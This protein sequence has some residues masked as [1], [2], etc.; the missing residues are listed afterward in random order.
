MPTYHY[1]PAVGFPMIGGSPALISEDQ[2]TGCCCDPC[3]TLTPCTQ[4]DTHSCTKRDDCCF[5]DESCLTVVVNASSLAHTQPGEDCCTAHGFV[6]GISGC[7]GISNCDGP[8]YSKAN[9]GTTCPASCTTDGDEGFG[10]SARIAISYADNDAT[11]TLA[12]EAWAY[13]EDATEETPMAFGRG[14]SDCCVDE[15]TI[16]L[17]ANQ[18]ISW[19]GSLSVTFSLIG[20]RCCMDDTDTCQKQ[21]G[22]DVCDVNDDTMD[23]DDVDGK[24]CPS[25]APVVKVTNDMRTWAHDSEGGS[26]TGFAKVDG[27]CYAITLAADC[28][29]AVTLG[30]G[31]IAGIEEVPQCSDCCNDNY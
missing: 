23:C 22:L 24:P 13:G 4:P 2:I 29:G 25:S 31:I 19:T 14:T 16:V 7:G 18:G 30:A 6:T 8:S 11:G 5:S 1:D 3:W 28:A 27:I 9:S 26:G 17:T 15:E 21:D 10:T 12:W 20:N